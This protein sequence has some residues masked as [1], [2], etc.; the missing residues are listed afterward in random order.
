MPA[1]VIERI[2]PAALT[3]GRRARCSATSRFGARQAHA[4]PTNSVSDCRS[5]SS[6]RH[7]T[8]G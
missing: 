6:S 3:S 7:S 2:V 4:S 5:S 1:D 8:M